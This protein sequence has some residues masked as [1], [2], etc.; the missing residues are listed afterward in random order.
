MSLEKLKGKRRPLCW[1]R[2]IVTWRGICVGG[3]EWVWLVD[4]MEIDGVGDV[5][6]PG[7]LWAGWGRW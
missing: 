4:V 2:G 7:V 3:A 6:V 1:G 5:V